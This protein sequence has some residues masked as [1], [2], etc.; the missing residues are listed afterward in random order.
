MVV[1]IDVDNTLIKSSSQ[2]QVNENLLT[3]LKKS[4]IKDIYLFTR[5]NISNLATQIGVEMGDFL[6]Q[7]TYLSR[8]RLIKKLK[9]EYGINVL[10]VITHE[11][12]GYNK[13]LGA[14]Y[15]DY[16]VPVNELYERGEIGA[17]T[18]ALENGQ[19][20]QCYAENEKYEQAVESFNTH[21][22]TSTTGGPYYDF[23]NREDVKNHIAN[24]D[25][26][27]QNSNFEPQK[28]MMYEYFINSR[29]FGWGD[30]IYF[31]DH[32]GALKAAEHFHK[33]AKF[34]YRGEEHSYKPE[35]FSGIQVD[36][37]K[38]SEDF[39]IYSIEKARLKNTLGESGENIICE[40][41]KA[42]AKLQRNS[43]YQHLIKS[44]KA[45]NRMYELPCKKT[46]YNCNKFASELSNI[47]PLLSKEIFSLSTDCLI[48]RVAKAHDQIEITKYGYED[49][50]SNLVGAPLYASEL[51]FKYIFSN[52]LGLEPILTF[53]HNQTLKKNFKYKEISLPSYGYQ[54]RLQNNYFGI[55][56]P[57]I[58]GF[59]R[60]SEVYRLSALTWPLIPTHYV[61][62]TL[63]K[64]TGH[65]LISPYAV[66]V[67]L[68]NK[69][70]Y[71]VALHRKFTSLKKLKNLK[72]QLP[73]S[74]LLPRMHNCDFINHYAV[75]TINLDMY[76]NTLK[77]ANNDS[78]TKILRV[79]P[80]DYINLRIKAIKSKFKFHLAKSI[81]A[82]ILFP[83]SLIFTKP[84]KLYR[85]IQREIKLGQ[86]VS[87]AL[88]NEDTTSPELVLY[89]IGLAYLKFVEPES[90]FEALKDLKKES[91]SEEKYRH[92]MAECGH[93]LLAEGEYENAAEYFEKAED[94]H[95]A[96]VARNDGEFL[97]YSDNETECDSTLYESE[98]ENLYNRTL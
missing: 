67:F 38:D 46:I 14:A 64:I 54:V 43:S 18:I 49:R 48:N 81:M 6:E 58:S 71:K 33:S 52:T 70:F 17:E 29:R 94:K 76:F 92:A 90:A 22:G 23:L 85:D 68:I 27:S 45:L 74:A 69:F 86:I 11:D 12:P 63:G 97:P 66:P 73:S 88:E 7:R 47:E 77:E 53:L 44:M 89:Q 42:E 83:P 10:S 36:I 98:E 34:S 1:L 75:R 65:L 59:V 32:L 39:Y 57:A 21:F 19:I 50:K 35:S 37:K 5:M 62:K 80:K 16:Y 96:K 26:H 60:K 25:I 56:T 84:L 55:L 41:E 79:N 78:R 13:G 28:G 87:E 61:F 9:E 3:A 15:N 91:I 95:A 51:I 93:Y 72:K 31:D 82:G 40:L 2:A 30:V 20:V 4:K 24:L 8:P